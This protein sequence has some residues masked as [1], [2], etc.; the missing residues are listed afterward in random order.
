ME[1]EIMPLYRYRCNE[2][3]HEFEELHGFEDE[4]PECPECESETVKR[5]IVSAP[6]FAKGIEAHAGDSRSSTKEQLRAK[7]AEE[8]PKLRKKLRD[9]MGD[10][11]VDNIPTLNMDIDP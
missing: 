11:A 6:M 2:C 4:L 1:I 8:T 9:K 3:G 5:L 10:E 7:W